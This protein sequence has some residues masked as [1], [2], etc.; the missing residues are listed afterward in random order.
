MS[1]LCR[2]LQEL[3][4]WKTVLLRRGNLV[5]TVGRS[6]ICFQAF[7]LVCQSYQKQAFSVKRGL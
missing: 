4:H 5:R 1:V 7:Y 2:K 3:L 6:K